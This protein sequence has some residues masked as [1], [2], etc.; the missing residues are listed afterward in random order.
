[1]TYNDGL[2][3][4]EE[5][6]QRDNFSSVHNKNIWRLVTELYKAFSGICPNITKYIFLLSTS[7]ILF[8]YLFIYLFIN[9]FIVDCFQM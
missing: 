4:F 6:L 3:S 5:V 9:L 1:M 2:S 7:S 8:I